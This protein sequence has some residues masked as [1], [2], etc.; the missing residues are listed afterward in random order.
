ML[1]NDLLGKTNNIQAWYI[2]LSDLVNLGLILASIW[3]MR[4]LM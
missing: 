1:R 4:L 3:S 2:G